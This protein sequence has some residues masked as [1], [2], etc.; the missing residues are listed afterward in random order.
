MSKKTRSKQ[1]RKQRRHRAQRRR[2]ERDARMAQA[3]AAAL[4]FASEFLDENGELLDSYERAMKLLMPRGGVV[5][6]IAKLSDRTP[7]RMWAMDPWLHAA[8]D[9]RRETE[10]DKAE[11]NHADAL[12]EAEEKKLVKWIP[13]PVPADAEGQKR[14]TLSNTDYVCYL[15]DDKKWYIGRE[16][17]SGLE[18]LAGNRLN[19]Q[20]EQWSGPYVSEAVAQRTMLHYL[21]IGANLDLQPD[22]ALPPDGDDWKNSAKGRN[23]ALNHNH[24]PVPGESEEQSLAIAATKRRRTPTRAVGFLPEDV[25]LASNLE[26]TRS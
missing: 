18:D 10:R 12:L 11:L 20:S 16:L 2:S 19:V 9:S 4:A 25:R 8:M 22:S 7:E 14:S 15:A 26:R 5:P 23:R 24:K 21:A 13:E 1:A 17:W 6:T 3:E